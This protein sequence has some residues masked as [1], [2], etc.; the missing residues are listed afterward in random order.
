MLNINRLRMLREIAARGTLA[1]AAQAL[2]MTPSAVSQQMAVLEREAGTPLLERHGRTVRLT[3]AGAKLV[4]NTERILAE[5]EHAEADLAAASH[6]VVGSVHVGAFATAATALLIP[7]LPGLAERYRNLR[8]TLIDLEPE[9]S[10]PE[11][12][13]HDLD[14]AI[15]YGWS[16][17]PELDDP[18][19]ERIELFQEP[20]Y[21]ALPKG[22]RLLRQKEVHVSDLRDEEWMIWRGATSM[23]DIIFSAARRAGFDPRT[24]YQLRDMSVVLSAVEAGLGV[25]ITPSLMLARP[26]YAGL[27]FTRIADFELTR[28]IS[29]SIRKGSRG[30]PAIAAVLDA[31][32]ESAAR[33]ADALPTAGS[34]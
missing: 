26:R 23:L 13:S 4:E 1:A 29:A 25:A 12:K 15:T 6:G 10:L 33:V 21:L 9:E 32:H 11:L 5:I 28:T 24:D 2:F 16:V 8:V 19:V 30:N 20:V 7:A 3:T 34:W 18:G 14:I 22:H 17:L 31:L 27:A